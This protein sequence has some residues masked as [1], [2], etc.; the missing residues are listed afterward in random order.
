MP[1]R[2]RWRSQYKKGCHRRDTDREQSRDGFPALLPD[3]RTEDEPTRADHGEDCADDIGGPITRI[4]HVADASAP[5]ED[6]R[7]DQSLEQE[8]DAPGQDC[9]N[10]SAES[11]VRWRQRSRPPPRPARRR[12]PALSSVDVKP[13]VRSVPTETPGVASVGALSATGGAVGG[14][15]R[16]GARARGTGRR[17]RGTSCSSSAPRSES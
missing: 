11:A 10:E 12:A 7:E 4:R 14:R 15:G 16:G 9:R 3:E 2:L 8:A 1:S 6:G 13:T 17:P 5:R